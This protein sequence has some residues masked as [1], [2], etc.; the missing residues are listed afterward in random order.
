MCQQGLL[1]EELFDIA[2]AVNDA[3]HLGSIWQRAIK[4]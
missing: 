2:G 1:L 4:D 3:Y